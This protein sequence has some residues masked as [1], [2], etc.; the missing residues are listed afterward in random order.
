M[1]SLFL[2]TTLFFP[3]SV[4]ASYQDV[5]KDA[6][7][8]YFGFHFMIPLYF[9]KGIPSSIVKELGAIFIDIRS[10][11]DAASVQK[12]QERYG[13]VIDTLESKCK[14]LCMKKCLEA[15]PHTF[16]KVDE[17]FCAS[18]RQKM[19]NWFY[20]MFLNLPSRNILFSVNV[21]RESF[22]V[23]KLELKLAEL[24][25]ETIHVFEMLID[26]NATGLKLHL[27]S[28]NAAIQAM[29]DICRTFELCQVNE[30]IV[31]AFKIRLKDLVV[32]N[33]KTSLPLV[34]SASVMVG[35][36]PF[37][38]TTLQLRNFFVCHFDQNQ[39]ITEC[40][41]HLD[42]IGKSNL[43]LME[44]V[45]RIHSFQFQYPASTR[46]NQRFL[47]FLLK[48]LI[49]ERHLY[50][51]NSINTIFRK[52]LLE[53][54]P[55]FLPYSYPHYF[56][57]RQ[58]TGSEVKLP[59]FF[60]SYLNIY[61]PLFHDRFQ[62]HYR[63]YDFY[64]LCNYAVYSPISDLPVSLNKFT[65]IYNRFNEIAHKK[66]LFLQSLLNE[67]ETLL[68]A[69]ELFVEDLAGNDYENSLELF[70][71]TADLLHFYQEQLILDMHSV[72]DLLARSLVWFSHAYSKESSV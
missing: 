62:I 9:N 32:I 65:D 16:L 28:I 26:K 36:K 67:E 29:V 17:A 41:Q 5:L 12:A 30:R 20:Y 71:C 43:S 48:G 19:I 6:P 63:S 1:P 56:I 25:N 55:S 44:L 61:F 14:D 68:H 23:Q 15:P 35:V 22:D 40:A 10:N 3:W 7:A 60:S 27:Y 34:S 38:A 72:T 52:H 57:Q 31:K 42:I 13:Q 49:R 58:L 45:N 37:Q 59:Q 33:L 21:E 70:S 24:A 11:P 50:T 2:L 64:R 39:S 4:L 46:S 8:S 51:P 69:F 53:K 47:T 66:G 18:L 54:V